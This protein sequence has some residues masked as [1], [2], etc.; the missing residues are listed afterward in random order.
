MINNGWIGNYSYFRARINP[1]SV[2]VH[3]L[4]ENE[5]YTYDEL[6]QRANKLANYFKEVFNL[7][8]GDRVAF[9]ARNRIEL[10]DAYYATGKTGTILVPY[11]A[12]LSVQELTELVLKEKPKVLFY[13]D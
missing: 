13:E 11:N 2:A 10:I 5:M 1:N 4:D 9:I 3:D 8:Q 12:R 6:D 7:S